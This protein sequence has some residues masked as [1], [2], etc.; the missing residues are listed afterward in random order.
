MKH[1]KFF[2]SLAATA[3][4]VSG[5]ARLLWGHGEIPFTVFIIVS[6]GTAFAIG[7][8]RPQRVWFYAF[9][10]SLG[11]PAVTVI[12]FAYYFAVLGSPEKLFPLEIVIALVA[13]FSLSF[14]GAGL[15]VVLQIL[16]KQERKPA[17]WIPPR[18]FDR[19]LVILLIA[20]IV[21][22]PAYLVIFIK[23][24]PS[25]EPG[26]QL[27]S[28]LFRK[29]LFI[30]KPE[31][32]A[33][34]SFSV[35]EN[36]SDSEASI[37][38]AGNMGVVTL[39]RSGAVLSVV[40][41]GERAGRVVPVDVDGDGVFEYMNKGG[42][43]QPVS[44]IDRSGSTLW[45]YSGSG[46]TGAPDEMTSIVNADGIMEFVVGLNGSA[47]L[48][49]LDM[50]GKELRSHDASNV[51]SVASVDVDGDGSLEVV[52]TDQD[53]III[54][55]GMGNLMK[56]L[57]IPLYR[58]AVCRWFRDRSTRVILGIDGSTLKAFDFEGKAVASLA[59]PV[60][61]TEAFAVPVRFGDHSYLAVAVS[62][63]A[64]SHL[65]MLY[66]FNDQDS[67][68]YHEVFPGQYP[69]IDII[70]GRRETGDILLAGGADG[71]VNRYSLKEQL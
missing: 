70:P 47:G 20:V 40:N 24:E 25:L 56:R 48:K 38:V 39:T 53:A 42:G 16:R 19:L 11:V 30:S 4:L 17:D 49:A 23:A 46:I 55:S 50:Q 26:V 41:F 8:L 36:V 9:I 62:L 2:L 44:L 32:G 60:R 22:I 13:G 5:L 34:T 14:I 28:E 67:L 61:G 29:D 54:R 45:K 69:S 31:I 7:V 63:L 57:E 58:F 43:W 68:V 27:G 71:T 6:I 52:H 59:V 15:G 3:G 18:H 64:S 10:T 65:S 35:L 1:H 33:V 66:I 21:I 12:A 51:F 37:I